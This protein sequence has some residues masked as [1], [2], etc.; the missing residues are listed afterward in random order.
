M[1]EFI[2]MGCEMGTNTRTCL[3]YI[4]YY[5]VLDNSESSYPSWIADNWLLLS[6]FYWDH[7]KAFK[8]LSANSNSVLDWDILVH[9]SKSFI[10]LSNIQTSLPLL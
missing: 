5:C 9:Y 2:C 10:G 7:L 8:P 1:K 6:D 4:L 3:R